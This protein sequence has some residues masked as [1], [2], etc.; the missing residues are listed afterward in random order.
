MFTKGVEARLLLVV[1]DHQDG[2]VVLVTSIDCRLRTSKLPYQDQITNQEILIKDT[3]RIGGEAVL[4]PQFARHSYPLTINISLNVQHSRVEVPV[5]VI[6]WL[7]SQG[8]SWNV[9]MARTGTCVARNLLL[10]RLSV[11]G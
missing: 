1:V 7:G 11:G 4:V 6:P 5:L 3:E 10:L 2:V 9:A 8:S